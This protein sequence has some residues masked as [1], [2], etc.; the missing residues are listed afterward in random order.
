MRIGHNILRRRNELRWSQELLGQKVGK[1]QS[2]ISRIESNLLDITLD[3]LETFAEAMETTPVALLDLPNMTVT[4]TSPTGGQNGNYN[5]NNHHQLPDALQK[6]L[7]AQIEA[8]REGTQLHR[9]EV[10]FYRVALQQM[11]EQTRETSQQA[12]QML[13]YLKMW[14][15]NQNGQ[16]PSA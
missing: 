11:I 3:E 12:G 2:E 4:V 6:M 15:E 1:K 8:H 9:E 13:E 10:Q 7:Q 5:I 14:F 16:R